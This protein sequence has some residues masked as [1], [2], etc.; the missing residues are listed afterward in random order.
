MAT[1]SVEA[2]EGVQQVQVSFEPMA[3]VPKSL[4]QRFF[5]EPQVPGIGEG[6]RPRTIAQ[7]IQDRR[8]AIGSGVGD[9]VAGGIIGALTLNGKMGGAV[10]TIRNIVA[11]Q[12]GLE[13]V[14]A[15]IGLPDIPPHLLSQ[16]VDI[17]AGVTAVLCIA[18]GADRL[19]RGLSDTSIIHRLMDAELQRRAHLHESALQ[20]ARTDAEAAKDPGAFRELTPRENALV[21]G[22]RQLNGE[23]S[24]P[25]KLY[26]RRDSGSIR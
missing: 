11:S 26:T 16:T 14:A 21:R 6:M 13:G 23:P 22:E 24:P 19:A 7:A 5:I 8:N 9:V 17:A 12:G 10:D 15:R 3:A 18:Y 1:V 20:D 25:R 2:Q 4:P